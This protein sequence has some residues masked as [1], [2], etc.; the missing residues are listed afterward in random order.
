MDS[1][2]PTVIALAV[3]LSGPPALVALTRLAFHA[4]PPLGVSIALQAVYCS[5][6]G[7]VIWTILRKE[8]LPLASIGLRAPR[9][10]TLA[11]GAAL[12]LVSLLL[13]PLALRPLRAWV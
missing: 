10:S 4:A 2:S 8:R 9:W 1:R 3:G 13:L 11:G 6:A 7:F 5:I 12:W